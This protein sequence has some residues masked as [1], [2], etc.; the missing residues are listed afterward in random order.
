MVVDLFLI[1]LPILLTG[2]TQVIKAVIKAVRTGEP[3]GKDLFQWGGFPSSHAA[4]VSSLAVSV[5][6][7]RGWN[8]TDFMLVLAFGIIVLRDAM[9][10]REF[11]EQHSQAINV[12]RK[13]LPPDQRKLVPRQ[14]DSVGHSPTEVVGG[15][16]IGAVLTLI[17]YLLLGN[18]PAL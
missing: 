17:V 16:V 10:L 8:S 15:V 2:L 11:V 1:T 4:L 9:G 7:L 3:R 14:V 18:V 13:N 12:I 6:L 5:I